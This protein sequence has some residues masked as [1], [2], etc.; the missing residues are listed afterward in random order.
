MNITGARARLENVK[1]DGKR[2]N[3]AIKATGDGLNMHRVHMTNAG[4]GISLY[5]PGQGPKDGLLTECYIDALTDA[6]AGFHVDGIESNCSRFRMSRCKILVP[7]SQT[8]CINHGIGVANDVAVFDVE[9][10]DNY[11]AGGGWAVYI[12]SKYGVRV[13]G[14]KVT[15]NEFGL[16]FFP[17]CGYWG[18]VF[19][20]NRADV[21]APLWSGNKFTDGT[22]VNWVA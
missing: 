18:P 6:G 16:D 15:G 12:E 2:L 5:N 13:S 22:I 3:Y 7:T 14:V 10:S 17:R 9:Y 20:G 21:E 11:F 19:Q 8:G 1:V 4:N